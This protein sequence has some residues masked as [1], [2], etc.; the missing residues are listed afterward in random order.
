MTDELLPYYNRELSYIRRLGVEFADAYPKIAT[1]LRLGSDVSED[2]HVERLIEAFAYLTARIRHKLDDDFPE[3]TDALLGALYPHYLAPFPSMAIAQFVLDPSQSELTA[4]YTIARDS[5]IETEPIQGEPCRFRTCYPV[6]LWPIELKSASLSRPPFTAPVTPHTPRSAGVLRLVLQCNAPALTFSALELGSLR[7]FLRGQAQHIYPLYELLFNNALGVALANSSRDTNPVLLDKQALKQVGFERDENLLPYSPRSLRA[8]GLLTEYFTFPEKYLFVELAGL[9]P[10]TLDQI[11]NQLEIYVYL[12]RAP[13]DLVQNV[14]ADTFR[15]GCAPMVNLFRQR[16][17]PIQLT[18]THYE[19]RVV[20]DVR[21]PQAMEVYS[22]DR[23]SATSPEGER[24]EF[25][26]F[27]SVKHTTARR[28]RHQYWFATRRPATQSVDRMDRGTEVYLSL[29]DLGFNPAVPADWTVEVETTCLNRDLPQRLPFGGDQ[30]RLYL[31]E[32]AA[33]VSRIQCL[34]PPTQ[35]LRPAR[36]HGAMWKFISHL[37]LNH[38]S[39]VDGTNGADALR[40]ILKLYEL[41][42]SE[43]RHSV[44]DGVTSVRMRRVSSRTPEAIGGFCRGLEVTVQLDEERFSGSGPFLFACVLERFLALYCSINSFSKLIATTK[45]RE[46]ALRRWPP[47][48]G[49]RVLL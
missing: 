37:T 45:Q 6:T 4:G 28:E 38:L 44:I 17:E 21:R 16:A 43:D 31:S 42:D 26:P 22:L 39:L 14:S 46:G 19:Y 23:V 35:T 30:P 13:T 27:F 3:I 2:P 12:S 9:G 15:L 20:P 48:A 10:K 32:G 18:H 1:R 34:T 7:F 24:T 47:R 5:M 33:V 41:S 49:E 11:G 40:E 8:Y 29:V 36:K 25:V